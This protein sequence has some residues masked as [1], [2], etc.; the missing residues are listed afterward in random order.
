[1]KDFFAAIFLFFL[2][3]AIIVGGII[4]A[5]NAIERSQN[6][7]LQKEYEASDK[8]YRVFTCVKEYTTDQQYSKHS[9]YTRYFACFQSEDGEYQT[10]E[11]V[12]IKLT[13]NRSLD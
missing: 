3:G 9:S 1:M 12:D 10:F 5:A 11:M 6:Q 4:S 7:T 13:N 2:L 8:D